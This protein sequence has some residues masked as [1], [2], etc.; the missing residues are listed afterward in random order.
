M[1]RRSDLPA[2]VEGLRREVAALHVELTRNR[3]VVWTAGNVSA[4]VPGENLM[5]IKPSGLSYDDISRE[6][7]VVTDL[8]GALIDGDLAPS[9]DT[10][11]HAYVYRHMPEV[12]GVAHTHSTYATAWAARGEP[13]PCVLTM[14]ADEF[15]GEVPIGPFALIGDDSI[16]EGIVATLRDS[17]SPAVLMRNHGPFTIGRDARAAVKAAVMVEEVARAIHLVAAAG[18]AISHQP[19]ATSTP[20]ICATRTATGRGTSKTRRA[21]DEALRRPRGLVPHRK[22][23]ACTARPSW[24]RSPSSRRGVAQ[25]LDDADGMPVEIVWKPVLTDA[26]AIR[27]VM[28]DATSDD[29]VLGVITWMHTFSPAKMWIAGLEA[30]GKPLLHLHT[31]ANVELPWDSIDFD[32]MNLNQAAHG[33]RE[34]GYLQTRLGL[35]RTTVAGHTSNPVV[36]ERVA[37][38]VRAAAGWAATHELRLVRFGDNMRDVA[39]TEGDKTRGR[40]HLRGL[41]QHLRR[42]RPGRR[43]RCRHRCRGRPRWSV[44]T[45]RRTTWLLSCA[46]GRSGMSRCAT[47]PGRSS[48]CAACWTTSAPR[49]SPPT[50]RT[51]VRCVSCP[52]SPCS[53]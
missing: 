38:W 4:R 22:P 45:S 41:G 3:L 7:M 6:S 21:H 10:A 36:R 44:S 5:V 34:H 32:F 15:G 12:G 24:L 37:T 53:G 9:S 50:S 13:I 20:S 52:G 19:G 33:D 17:R 51:S 43:G 11:A 49:R 1:T 47:R 29:R 27:R 42:Q 39:V 23:D 35:P 40:D 16:G 2:A 26:T 8:H 28:L 31:Q 14:M 25:A 18:R 46:A 30:L 48:A